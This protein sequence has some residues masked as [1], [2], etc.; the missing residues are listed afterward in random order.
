MNAFPP[1][2]PSLLLSLRE[3]DNDDAWRRFVELYLPLT[4]HY[5]VQRGLQEADA[6]DVAQEVM[7]AVAG[8]IREFNYDPARGK[9]RG[10]LLQVTRNKLNRF[11]SRHYRDPRATGESA[12]VRLA[13]ETPGPEEQAVWEEEYQQRV[14]DWA[15]ERVRTEVQDSTWQAFW[16]TAVENLSVQETAHRLGITVGTVYVAR[17]RVLA[18]LRETVEGVTDEPWNENIAAA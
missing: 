12:L 16:L 6:A 2:R 1:T 15:A 4:F 7:L 8:G 11:L 13:E 17:S 10:W 9:F 3:A 18:R 5:C 14:F